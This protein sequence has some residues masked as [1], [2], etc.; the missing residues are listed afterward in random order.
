M[1]IQHFHTPCSTLRIGFA[2]VSECVSLRLHHGHPSPLTLTACQFY[3]IHLTFPKA[4]NFAAS[5]ARNNEADALPQVQ[6][7]DIITTPLCDLIRGRTFHTH[8]TEICV[9]GFG[10]RKRSIH[11]G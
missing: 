1:S 8:T 11:L 10:G 4:G 2:H 9:G 3:D 7:G 6:S 5:P